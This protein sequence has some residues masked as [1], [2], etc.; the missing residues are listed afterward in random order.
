MIT[1]TVKKGSGVD[2]S[3]GWH[4][5]EITNA[6]YATWQD[7]RFLELCFKG[8]PENFNLRVYAKASSNGEEFAISNVFRFA[9]AGISAETLSDGSGDMTLKIDDKPQHLIGKK[10]NIFFY[11]QENNGKEYTR[12]YT[13]VAPIAL[14]GVAETFTENDVAY[15]MK[16]AEER[17]NSYTPEGATSTKSTPSTVD[18]AESEAVIPF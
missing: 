15:W 4:E 1:L 12:A 7:N 5:L 9:N 13:N 17:F 14:K 16:R 18:E 11:K 2:Y 3:P 10:L 8:Y 6:K